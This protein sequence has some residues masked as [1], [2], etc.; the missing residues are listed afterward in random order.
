MKLLRYKKCDLI[1]PTEYE[2]RASV[3]D[4]QSGLVVLS[5]KLRSYT[6]HYEYDLN[7]IGVENIKKR[8][9]NNSTL[10]KIDK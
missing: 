8:I 6:H 5:E 3:S 1:T 7:P 2:A 4:N 9:Q 10:S